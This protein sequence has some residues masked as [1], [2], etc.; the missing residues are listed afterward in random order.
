MATDL[1]FDKKVTAVPVG[2][3]NATTETGTFA[4]QSFYFGCILDLHNSVADLA[5]TCT[6]AVC[7][8]RVDGVA[9]PCERFPFTVP[10]AGA[11]AKRPLQ[12]VQP[13]LAF[14]GV[15]SVTISVVDAPLGKVAQSQFA[16]ILDDVCHLNLLA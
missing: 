10:A 12:L 1:L 3:I 7:G 6:I 13:S 14:V 5:E 2:T 8:T 9:V 16:I 4:L 11:L 15:H